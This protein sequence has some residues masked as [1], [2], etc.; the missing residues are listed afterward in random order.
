MT[1]LK[2]VYHQ[3]NE[4]RKFI[5]MI[6]ETAPESHAEM[7]V[8]LGPPSLEELDLP[9]QLEVKLNNAL[10]A[11]NIITPED[12]RNTELIRDA[13]LGALKLDAQKIA[14]LYRGETIA[15]AGE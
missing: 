5:Y 10:F 7:G 12:A 9:L 4:G 15:L 3:D 6:P 11:R 2:R 13:I 1:Q 14:S 8:L